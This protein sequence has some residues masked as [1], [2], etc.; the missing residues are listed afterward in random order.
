M[1]HIAHCTKQHISGLWEC[2][3]CFK[4]HL[5]IL[6][7][8]K[9]ASRHSLSYVFHSTSIHQL[10]LLLSHHVREFLVL[11]TILY[12]ELILWYYQCFAVSEQS[13]PLHVHC[14]P[15][16]VYLIDHFVHPL[17][18]PITIIT[19]LSALPTSHLSIK[20]STGRVHV[21]IYS[22]FSLT[23]FWASIPDPSM[24]L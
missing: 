5:R 11:I 9:F 22:S 24:C 14:S 1:R 8:Q 23:L 13:I 18:P 4:F 15:H 17:I 20:H 12:L 3:T 7:D 6:I 16:L 10:L 2:K 19:I 21:I